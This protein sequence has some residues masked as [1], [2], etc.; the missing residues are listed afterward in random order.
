MRIF[1]LLI[2]M[3]LMPLTIQAQDI[4]QPDPPKSL[5]N[6]V[7][8]G[9]QIFYLGEFEGMNGWALIRQGKPEFF[10]E[11]RDRTAMV[12]G[13]MFNGDGEMITMGQLTTLNRRVGD[14]MYASTGGSLAQHKQAQVAQPSLVE[15][16]VVT[17]PI[18]REL[19]QAQRMY[20]DLI[21][22]NW[23]TINETGKHDVF[24]FIDPDC[25]HCKQMIREMAPAFEN[26]Q[27]R[28][29]VIPLGIADAG[30]RKASVLLSS[31]NPE[32]RLLKYANGDSDALSA[33]ENINTKAVEKNKKTLL[34]WGF[35]AT[36]IVVYRTLKGEIRVVRGRPYDLDNLVKDIEMN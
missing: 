25:P 35:D 1:S 26:D 32:E 36:P 20:T 11:N 2:L 27:I 4:T 16:P 23:I 12:M 10:Y 18:V 17:A 22:S 13:L 31:A 33:P 7:E 9:A 3:F 8:N 34:K 30:Q 19:T 21:A 6:M 28:L 5:K 14:D 15:E 24:A 29:R